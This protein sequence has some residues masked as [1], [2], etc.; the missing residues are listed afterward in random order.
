MATIL[1]LKI[2]LFFTKTTVLSHTTAKTTTKTTARTT[3]GRKNSMTF[4]LG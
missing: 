1:S 4:A 2:L 3:N